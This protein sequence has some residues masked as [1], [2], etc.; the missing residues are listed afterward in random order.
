MTKS[1]SKKFDYSACTVD[2][3]GKLIYLA[4]E[5]NKI[6][7]RAA[8]CVI[9]IGKVI[10]TAKEVLKS[11]GDKTLVEWLES[12]TP[13]S[14]STGY[15]AHAVFLKFGD[16][17]NLGMM[18]DSALYELTSNRVPD[19]AVKECKKLANSGERINYTRAKEIIKKHV[20]KEEAE[21]TPEPSANGSEQPE[22]RETVVSSTPTPEPT[23]SETVVGQL[24]EEGEEYEE[25]GEFVE[26]NG[27]VDED[28][29]ASVQE[30][31]KEYAERLR[32]LARFGRKVLGAEGNEVKRP[33]CNRYSLITL[34]HPLH[35]V[36]R[37]VM[38]D[39]PVGGKPDDPKLH[40]EEVAEQR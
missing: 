19:S 5:A 13:W 11:K 16:F 22:S 9:D 18:E 15:R 30:D 1:I 25:E 23:V 17:P 14:K 20:A 10:A 36:A 31:L 6:A 8:S 2:E 33:W 40:R 37:T 39:M 26:G 35:H 21:S 38:N 3:K 29:L 27:A 34:I 7:S 28:S 24:V 12:E 32:E 4:A